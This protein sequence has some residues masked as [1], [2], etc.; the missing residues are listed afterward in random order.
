MT[1]SLVM[2]VHFISQRIHHI[3]MSTQQQHT[4]EEYVGFKQGVTDVV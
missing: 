3:S 4:Q 2:Y 1:R